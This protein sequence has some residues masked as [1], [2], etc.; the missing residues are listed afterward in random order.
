MRLIYEPAGRAREYAPLA[1]NLYTGCT[2]ACRYCYAPAAC[3]KD[4][5]AFHATAEPRADIIK[6]L[7]RELARRPNGPQSDGDYPPVLL[8]F[9]SDPYQPAAESGVTRRAIE[10][11]HEAGYP[12]HVLTKGGG[13]AVPDFD[14]LGQ[15]EHDAFAAT[16]T[17]TSAADATEWEPHAAP[18]NDRMLALCEAHARGIATWASLEPVI[19]PEQS[20]EL[21]RQTHGYVDLFKV[22]TLNHHPHAKT[23]DW[24]DFARRARALLEELGA[25]YYLKND[26]RR[27]LAS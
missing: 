11:L 3:R 24:P 27:H 4:A 25:R 8:S 20:L 12:V 13:R 10:L 9:T 18:P 5:A 19:D 15:H 22:G 6:N 2:H 26:L 14:L 17:F 1:L 7:E 21:I 23:I 16:L